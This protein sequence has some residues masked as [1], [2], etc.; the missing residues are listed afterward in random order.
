MYS[1]GFSAAVWRTMIVDI[2][3]AGHPPQHYECVGRRQRKYDIG[4]GHHHSS[5]I[6]VYVKKPAVYKCPADLCQELKALAFEPIPQLFLECYIERTSGMT[7]PGVP[8][9]HRPARIPGP[10]QDTHFIDEKRQHFGRRSFLYTTDIT[11]YNNW[12]NIPG[13]RIRNGHRSH[14]CRPPHGILEVGKGPEPASTTLAAA[15][16]PTLGSLMTCSV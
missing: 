12:L 16:S 4:P 3:D 1:G 9:L 10:S 8:T 11:T 7:F 14:V 2:T 5:S 6:Y 13:W 15:R